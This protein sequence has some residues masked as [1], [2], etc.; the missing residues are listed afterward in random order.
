MKIWH[1]SLYSYILKVL[2][3]WLDQFIFLKEA[4]QHRRKRGIYY[5]LKFC[6][7]IAH[8]GRRIWSFSFIVAD[9]PWM[10]L[11][12]WMNQ[13]TS[14]S[15]GP[16]KQQ[17]EWK[18]K[19]LNNSKKTFSGLLYF[20]FLFKWAR[21]TLINWI[22]IKSNNNKNTPVNDIPVTTPPYPQSTKK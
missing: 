13:H 18:N 21:E 6:D 12:Q 7:H 16:G 22:R 10:Y 9:S 2:M 8:G 4:S 14:C 15:W 19:V 17:P 3:K 11:E 5:I 20:F 1:H